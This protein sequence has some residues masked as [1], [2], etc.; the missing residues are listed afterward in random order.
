[1]Y[2][3]LCRRRLSKRDIELCRKQS[4][5]SAL[6]TH[7]TLYALTPLTVYSISPTVV[8]LQVREH[9]EN[10]L[11]APGCLLLFIVVILLLFVYACYARDAMLY[12]FTSLPV[13]C[14][15]NSIKKQSNKIKKKILTNFAASHN[16]FFKINIFVAMSLSKCEQ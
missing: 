4:N 3:C 6:F 13:M 2:F 14:N 15:R 10:N 8:L 12:L 9:Y 1:M 11:E 16:R 5:A 7:C